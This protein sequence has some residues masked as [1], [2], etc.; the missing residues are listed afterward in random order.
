MINKTGKWHD[1][2]LQIDLFLMFCHIIM[3]I[4]IIKLYNNINTVFQI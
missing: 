4:T 3:M 2:C 1:F